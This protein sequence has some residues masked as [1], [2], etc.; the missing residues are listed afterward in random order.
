MSSPFLVLSKKLIEKS[1]K[2]PH[3]DASSLKNT[4]PIL[5]KKSAVSKLFI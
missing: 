1:N 4:P 5:M 2:K 3:K